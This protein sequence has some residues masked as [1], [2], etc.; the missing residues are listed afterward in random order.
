MADVRAGTEAD[1]GTVTQ[2]LSRAFHD[3]P[4]MLYLF[5]SAEKREPLLQSFFASEAKR[6][7][8]KG[9]LETA[10]AGTSQGAAVWFAPG[11]WKLGGF[12]MLTQLPMIARFGKQTVRALRLLG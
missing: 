7:L 10:G 6:A 12:E 5:P 2:A 8:A 1:I 4:V 11:H 9:K 3:D